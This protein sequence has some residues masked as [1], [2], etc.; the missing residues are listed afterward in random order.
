MIPIQTKVAWAWLDKMLGRNPVHAPQ[1][2]P[3]AKSVPKKEIFLDRV[4]ADLLGNLFREIDKAKEQFLRKVGE[5]AKAY[6]IHPDVLLF[7]VVDGKAWPSTISGDF[8]SS[9]RLMQTILLQR[10]F[11]T[12]NKAALM[13]QPPDPELVKSALRDLSFFVKGKLLPAMS[14]SFYKDLRQKSADIVKVFAEPGDRPSQPLRYLMAQF[15]HR[16]ARDK[17]PGQSLILSLLPELR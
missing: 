4:Y 15:E 5:V 13:A 10:G 2:Q 3:A 17:F 16:M 14:N 9:L 12:L 6:G 7:Y 1:E 8:R 11:P